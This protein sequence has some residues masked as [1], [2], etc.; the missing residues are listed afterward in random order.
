VPRDPFA[1]LKAIEAASKPGP[2]QECV[3][4]PN[5]PSVSRVRP[6]CGHRF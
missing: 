4:C 2:Y 1:A 6:N 3:G 5:H